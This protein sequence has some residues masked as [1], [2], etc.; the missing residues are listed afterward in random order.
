MFSRDRFIFGPITSHPYPGTMDARVAQLR[1]RVQRY[2]SYLREGLNAELAGFY[3]SQIGRDE[4]EL[5]KIMA[6]PALKPIAPSIV[7]LRPSEPS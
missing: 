2:R 1:L 5:E 4:R 3:L 6:K 7:R